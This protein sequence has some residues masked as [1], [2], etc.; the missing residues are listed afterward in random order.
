LQRS[1][2]SAWRVGSF[3][4]LAAGMQHGKAPDRG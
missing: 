3:S 1:L 4:G 2:H